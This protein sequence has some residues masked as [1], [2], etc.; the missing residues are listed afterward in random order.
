MAQAFLAWKAAFFALVDPL[1]GLFAGL[2]EIRIVLSL[3][4]PLR[5]NFQ[6][7]AL[8]L[9]PY[10]GDASTLIPSFS[11]AATSRRS[12]RSILEI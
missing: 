6:G 5:A 7:A 1:V 10:Q 9:G 12:C 4:D 3:N 8:P 11:A 2:N